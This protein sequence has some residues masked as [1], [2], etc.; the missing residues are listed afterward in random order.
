MLFTSCLYLSRV[1]KAGVIASCFFR[2]V[3]GYG[4]NCRIQESQ[5][6]DPGLEPR[7]AAPVTRAVSPAWHP[8]AHSRRRA[9]AERGGRAAPATQ[10]YI[11]PALSDLYHAQYRSLFRQAVLLTGVDGPAEAVVRDSVAA[12]YRLRKRPQTEDD[13]VPYLRRLL[14]AGHGW[15]GIISGTAAGGPPAGAG[16]SGCTAHE[17]LRPEGSAVTQLCAGC[18]PASG[19]DRAHSLPGPQSR[20]GR[21]GPAG[22]PGHAATPPGRGQVSVTGRPAFK[23]LR[24]AVLRPSAF[25]G[26]PGQPPGTR[27]PARGTLGQPGSRGEGGGVP[28][29]MSRGAMMQRVCMAG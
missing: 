17:A 26:Q 16:P 14:V 13:A 7:W 21:R 2:E 29:N 5:D 9:N 4:A 10:P 12:L 22:E 11:R 28:L 15:P 20:A 6:R 23:A 18:Q 19:S 25:A 24:P 8:A 27:H 1:P 3:P